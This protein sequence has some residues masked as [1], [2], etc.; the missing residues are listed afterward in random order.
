MHKTNSPKDDAIS[1][2]KFK[3]YGMGPILGN[4]IDLRGDPLT[5]VLTKL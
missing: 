3:S 5:K 2:K 4:A 1:F